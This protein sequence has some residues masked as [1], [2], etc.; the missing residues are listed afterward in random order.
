MKKEIEYTAEDVRI[1]RAIAISKKFA[2][3]MKVVVESAEFKA[4]LK[5]VESL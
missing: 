2:E 1:V 4:K 5:R 3:R